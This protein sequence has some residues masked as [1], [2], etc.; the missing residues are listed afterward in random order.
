LSEI[1]ALFERLQHGFD[2]LAEEERAKCGLKGVAVEISLKIDMNKREI[3]LDKL[4]KYCKMDF[5][6][7][8]ELLQILQHNFQD[9]TLI[10]PSLQGYEL[11][12][13][14]YRF[15][16]APTIECIYLKG[17][18]K[19][20]LLMGEALQEVAFGRILDD[21]QKH[22]NE[23]GGLEKR[24][25]V[26]ENGLEVSMYHRGREGEEEVLWMQVKIPLLPG[27]KIENYSYM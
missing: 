8:T 26:L 20:R 3:V 16:G 21:T 19:D 13:E 2:R 27:Q 9:F 23:L 5:H 22:Y 15:L 4:Y 24:D 1:S 14:I 25:D 6:L 11:A 18:T 17:D 10:V 12:R 7:F